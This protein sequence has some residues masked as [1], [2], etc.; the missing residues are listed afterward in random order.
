MIQTLEPT[1]PKKKSERR[2]ER[3]GWNY[4]RRFRARG[5]KTE[6]KDQHRD[7]HGMP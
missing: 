3:S 2:K 5:G 7:S 1:N 6:Q 4:L